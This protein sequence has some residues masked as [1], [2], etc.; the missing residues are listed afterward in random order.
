ML[1]QQIL[2]FISRFPVFKR[3]T[4]VSFIYALTRALMYIITSFGLVYLTEW[5]GHYGLWIITVP[6]SVGFLWG[7]KSFCKIR[8][9]TRTR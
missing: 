9:Y 2:F 5:Y 3:F 1:P 8:A 6:V 7:C 4:A